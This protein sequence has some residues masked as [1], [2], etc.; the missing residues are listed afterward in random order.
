MFIWVQVFVWFSVLVQADEVGLEAIDPA[1][2]G[3]EGLGL[4]EELTHLDKKLLLASALEDLDDKVAVGLELLLCKKEDL[5]G[6]PLAAGGVHGAVAGGHGG[7]VADYGI[8]RA[9]A[10]KLL[11]D[12]LGKGITHVG[13]DGRGDGV[14]IQR[15]QIDADYA[16]VA[17][18]EHAVGIKS[19]ASGSCTYIKDSV[20]GFYDVV[21]LL[22]FL[23][24]VDASGRV[25]LSVSPLGIRICCVPSACCHGIIVE[26]FARLVSCLIERPEVYLI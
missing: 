18:K 5:L 4:F 8:I 19:P 11:S 10:C 24:L 26:Q 21:R 1:G 23:Q 17:L 7:C 22:D 15:V 13:C 12:F 2:F 16:S 20:P 25:A 6:E 3:F 14:E 9:V